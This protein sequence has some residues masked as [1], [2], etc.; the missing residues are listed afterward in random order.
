MGLDGFSRQQGRVRRSHSAF[1]VAV[2]VPEVCFLLFFSARVVFSCWL[3][4]LF[5]TVS[6]CVAYRVLFVLVLRCVTFVS[7][8]SSSL[9]LS[10]PVLLLRCV[11]FGDGCVDLVLHVFPHLVR[12]ALVVRSLTLR[13]RIFSCVAA[14][15]PSISNIG[16]FVSYLSPYDDVFLTTLT[17]H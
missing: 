4:F 1:F 12:A 6:W 2:V 8:F 16:V 3:P 7:F 15:V 5:C 11:L 9:V 13:V 10:C 17:S 14:F